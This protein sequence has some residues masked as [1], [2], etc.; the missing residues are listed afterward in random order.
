MSA[1][2]RSPVVVTGLGAVSAWGWGTDAL[3]A[4]LASGTS[5]ADR[6][7][8]FDTCGQR[9]KLACEV[10]EAPAEIVGA[11]SDW[12]RSSRADRFALAAAREAARQ[13]DITVPVQHGARMGVWFGGSTAGMVEGERFF[14]SALG[15]G[16]RRPRLADLVAQPLNSPGD[17]IAR[18]LGARGPVMSISSACAS[19]TLALGEALDALRA[20]EV[21]TAVVG[22]ADSLCQLTYSG[23]NA[24]RAVDPDPSRPFR[25]ERAGLNLGEGA[26]VLIL[27]TRAHAAARQVPVLAEL[28]GHGGSCDAHHMTAPHPEGRGAAAA[29]RR[30][31][32]DAAL[33]ADE[34][35]FINAHGTGTPLN[36]VA[37]WH[38]LEDV[39]GKRA[40]A[41]PVTSV[42]GS[43]G[44]LLGSAGSIE[45]VATVCSLL[46]GEIPPTAGTGTID[47]AT[48]VDL[49]TDAP[50]ALPATD[51]L[52]R[53]AAVSTN[54]AFGGANAAVVFTSGAGP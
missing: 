25:E 22:G 8:C 40:R 3:W 41:L 1:T 34:V 51:P 19:G 33:A 7:R 38:A 23:F 24:L 36:D 26:G 16:S 43:I 35:D 37:E 54:F 53:T 18:W 10:P 5:R 9:T 14:R 12:E 30:A 6:P 32:S 27:E 45:A 50:R 42:K 21:D 52:R 11:F 13:A 49:V 15:D 28:L 29:M 4:G 46:T 39:F 48:A 17:A 31:L 47:P 20:G 44:H 2:E